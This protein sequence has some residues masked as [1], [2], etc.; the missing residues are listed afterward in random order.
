[1]FGGCFCVCSPP[2]ALAFLFCCCFLLFGFG[3]LLFCCCFLFCFVC[4]LL[5]CRLLLSFPVLFVVGVLCIE[6]YRNVF[7]VCL[8]AIWGLGGYGLWLMVYGNL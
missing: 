8:C 6:L 5:F 3:P 4:L 7:C 2:R 1:M